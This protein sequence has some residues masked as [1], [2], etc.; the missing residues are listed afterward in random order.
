MLSGEFG[1]V[2]VASM[3]GN[4]GGMTF[5]SLAK[6]LT[7]D[8]NLSSRVVVCGARARARGLLFIL[9]V[10]FRSAGHLCN[11]GGSRELYRS[12]GAAQAG[13]AQRRMV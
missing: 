7:T 13:G 2:H 3:T 4:P 12:D 5:G 10:L 8:A 6:A 1:V 9:N 11:P